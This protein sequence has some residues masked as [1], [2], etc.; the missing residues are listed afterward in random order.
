MAIKKEVAVSV[1]KSQEN[2]ILLRAKEW[3]FQG[4]A[5]IKEW[6]KQSWLNWLCE[7]GIHQGK[8][9]VDKN[10]KNP[11]AMVKYCSRCGGIIEEIAYEEGENWT[12]E[13]N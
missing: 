13:S 1:V 5:D 11:N 6:L 12:S 2:S 8:P 9:L 4:G 7:A 3:F 10:A